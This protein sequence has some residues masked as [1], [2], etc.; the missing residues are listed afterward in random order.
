MAQHR[1][2]ASLA[3][4]IWPNQGRDWTEIGDNVDAIRAWVY[5]VTT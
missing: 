3:E 2:K 1:R 5:E 4:H